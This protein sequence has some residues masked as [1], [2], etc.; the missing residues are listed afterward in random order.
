MKHTKGMRILCAVLAGLLVCAAVTFAVLADCGRLNGYHPLQTPKEGQVRVACVGDSVT[1][2]FGIPRRSKNCYPAVLQD[3]LGEEY[4]V[5]NYGYSGR[6]AC[7]LGDRPY[8]IETLCTE[9]REFSPDI[10]VILLGANDSKSFNWSTEIAGQQAYPT[11]FE[12]DLTELVSVYQG[13]PS[14]PAVY[15]ASLLPAYADKSGKVRYE[16][17]PEVIRNEILPIIDRIAAK[18]GVT[19]ID[20]FSVFDGKPSLFSDGLHPTAEGAA[21]LAQTVYAAITGT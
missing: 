4:C 2:G 15:L 16:I 12:A 14:H 17:Q 19:K 11:L 1:Y 3:L 9:S 6:T 20:L 5:N 10:V 13:L 21:L 8:R 18:T 7:L